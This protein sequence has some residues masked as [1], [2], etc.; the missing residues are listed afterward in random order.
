MLKAICPTELRRHIEARVANGNPP[1][2]PLTERN[3][4][5]KAYRM[6]AYKKINPLKF[7]IREN[8]NYHD[9]V[10]FLRITH[11][12]NM[13]AKESTSPTK[14]SNR[15]TAPTATNYTNATEGTNNYADS[16]PTCSQPNC[17]N[18]CRL[19]RVHRPFFIYHEMF[20]N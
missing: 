12:G 6:S 5:L 19:P 11:L 20:F 17:M 9:S 2:P 1:I 18:K 7:V 3:P 15:N 16:R 10:K 8:T 13:I 14:S 4:R